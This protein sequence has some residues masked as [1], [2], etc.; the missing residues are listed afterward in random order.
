MTQKWHYGSLT[1]IKE[2]GFAIA[3]TNIWKSRKFPDRQTLRTD[4][5][6]WKG[7]KKAYDSIK[8]GA[9]QKIINIVVVFAKIVNGTQ[10]LLQERRKTKS[11]L[12]PPQALPIKSFVSRG[13]HNIDLSSRISISTGC[14]SN[15][16]SKS[17]D[18]ST[19]ASMML[20][21]W[22]RWSGWGKTRCL[23]LEV[24]D[25]CW[26]QGVLLGRIEFCS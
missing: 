10:R 22:K 21:G 13:F 23:N 20:A 3:K 17:K 18:M 9:K 5:L 19:R 12:F 8:P 2:V 25:G 15:C 7:R 11:A 16:L 1:I 14:R 24:M 6:N 26:R 4:Q